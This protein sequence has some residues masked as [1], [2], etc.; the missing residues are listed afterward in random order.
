MPNKAKIRA[1]KLQIR[2]VFL[3]EWDPIGV[4]DEP[5]AQDEYDGYLGSIY[6]M[7]A[8]GASEAEIARRLNFHETVDMGGSKRSFDKL[9]SVAQSLK[10]I[11]L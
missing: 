4:A 1:A 7:L 9:L 3:E 2:R 10:R 6:D 8:R 11:A 5:L